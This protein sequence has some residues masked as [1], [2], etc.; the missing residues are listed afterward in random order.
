[1]ALD[2][3]LATARARLSR[4]LDEQLDAPAGSETARLLTEKARQ[5]EQ[6]LATLAADRERRGALPL[7]GLSDAQVTTLAAFA[8]EV[9]A[10]LSSATPAD[11]HAVLGLLGLRGAVRRDEQ[12]GC[13]LGRA[14]RFAVD[15]QAVLPVGHSDGELVNS[16]T[17]WSTRAS[18]RSGNS[19]R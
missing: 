14:H 3:D 7:A 9:R 17:N 10:G 6:H 15:W 12:Q 2:R 8:A 13:R 4:I 16:N 18:S 1:A 19:G 5:L 11:Q